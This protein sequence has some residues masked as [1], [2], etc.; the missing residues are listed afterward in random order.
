MIRIFLAAALLAAALCSPLPAASAPS[1]FP[2][3]PGSSWARRTFNGTLLTARVAGTKKVGAVRCTVVETKAV[4]RSA[5]TVSRVCYEATPTAVRVIENESGGR[6]YVFQPPRTM[7][8]LP[9]RAGRSWSWSPQGDD[10]GLTSTD[11]WVGEESVTVPAGTFKAWKLKT[12]TKRG[13]D[14]VTAITWYAPGVGVVRTAR[15][16]IRA[17]GKPRE[18][19][20]GLVNYTIP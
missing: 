7:L 10:A 20:S 6:S 17:G 12:V 14:T 8:I 19:G 1:Y 5:E 18:D 16:E 13:S 3:V 9:P 4:R 15:Q 2:L 11:Q